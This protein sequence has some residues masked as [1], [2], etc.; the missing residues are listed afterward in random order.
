MVNLTPNP[1]PTP[2]PRLLFLDE[3]TSGLDSASSFYLMQSLRRIAHIACTTI[4]CTIHQPSEQ[5]FRMSDR[6]LL[7]SSGELVTNGRLRKLTNEEMN[8]QQFI[9]RGRNELLMALV[10]APARWLV[11]IHSSLCSHY[12]GIR[13]HPLTRLGVSHSVL[14]FGFLSSFSLPSASLFLCADILLS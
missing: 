9:E 12:S 7:L 5:V 11:L 1:D 4:V 6:L 10:V 14:L 13:T 3:P 2:A 8:R